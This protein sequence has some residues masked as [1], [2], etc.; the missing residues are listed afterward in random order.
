MQVNRHAATIIGHTQR[1]V[2]MQHHIDLTAMPCERFINRIIDHLLSEMIR[3]SGIRVHA[4]PLTNGI[5]SGQYLDRI[6]VI[7]GHDLPLLV[8]SLSLSL[9]SLRW[10]QSVH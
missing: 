8:S 1:P 6:S 7:F 10:M 9:R 3:A 5:Q 2:A 4:R